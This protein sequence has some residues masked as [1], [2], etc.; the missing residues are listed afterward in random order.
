MIDL[1]MIYDFICSWLFEPPTLGSICIGYSMGLEMANE[2]F[3]C[4]P[5]K[6]V[7]LAAFEGVVIWYILV[8]EMIGRPLKILHTK[9]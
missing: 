2:V 3:V 9:F 6:E 1:I 7:L 8:C 4:F 5:S